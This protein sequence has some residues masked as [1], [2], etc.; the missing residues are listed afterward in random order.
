MMAHT[1]VGEVNYGGDF[2]IN[3]AGDDEE[4]GK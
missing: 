2:R 1:I 3:K 4:Y